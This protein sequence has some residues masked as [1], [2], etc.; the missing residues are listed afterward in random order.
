MPFFRNR[1]FFVIIF[2]VLF[3]VLSFS[4]VPDE[5]EY[6]T[7]DVTTEASQVVIAPDEFIRK[8][9]E[10]YQDNCIS[11]TRIM[12]ESGEASRYRY[13]Y[14]MRN[15]YNKVVSLTMPY[16]VT[17][18][19]YNNKG[20]IILDGKRTVMEDLMKDLED[21][22]LEDLNPDSVE[23]KTSE[24]LYSGIPAYYASVYGEDFT[25]RVIVLKQSMNFIRIEKQTLGKQIIMFYDN[26]NAGEKETFENQMIWYKEIPLGN[27]FKPLQNSTVT[28]NENASDTTGSVSSTEIQTAEFERLLASVASKYSVK[29][30]ETVEFSDAEAMF[31]TYSSEELDAPFV[32]SVIIY[33]SN[34]AQMSENLLG[35][36]PENYNHYQKIKENIE[37]NVIGAHDPSFL[38]SVAEMILQD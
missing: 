13:E 31:V 12:M 29:K 4:E 6:S 25:Y 11:G 22:F 21:V 27:S 28:T 19:R 36:I 3:F 9:K 37:V 26:L 30:T 16:R 20:Y 18:Y 34:S 38:K 15:G 10:A 1:N 35:K 32:V 7:L 5:K 23:I 14:I 33:K 17:W 2:S 24:I 8:I